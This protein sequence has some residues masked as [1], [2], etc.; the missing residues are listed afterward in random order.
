MSLV[1]RRYAEALADIADHAGELDSFGRELREVVELFGKQAELRLFLADPGVGAG[2]KKEILKKVFSGRV[3]AEILNFLMLLIDK[4]RI[5]R[6]PGIYT[7]Y[8]KE[9]DRRKKVLNITIVSAMPL[10]ETQINEIKEI[11]KNKYGASSVKEH[12][13][14]DKTLL[15]GVKVIV[16]DKVFDGTVK[17]RLEGLREVLLT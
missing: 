12:I 13:E 11:F 16:G 5:D 17:G 14:I 15:G 6:L 2:P 8:E 3:K 7:E 4:G 9:A 1:E 10:R